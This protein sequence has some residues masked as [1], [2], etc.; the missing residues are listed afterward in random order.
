MQENKSSILRN[1][2]LK[3]EKE[4][5]NNFT[6]GGTCITLTEENIEPIKKIQFRISGKQDDDSQR[7]P[8]S[9][10]KDLENEAVPVV[11]LPQKF[12]HLLPTTS[13]SISSLA[14]FEVSK[15]LGKGA[16]ATVH[17]IRDLNTN[18]SF[19]LKTYAKT[20]FTKP[21]RIENIQ[22]E[23]QILSSLTHPNIVKLHY[24]CET[25]TKVHLIM[26]VGGTFALD[27]FLSVQEGKRISERK[28]ARIIRQVADALSYMHS[29]GV[30]HRDIKLGNVLINDKGKICVIDFGFTVDGGNNKLKNYCGTPCYMSPEI[31]E[32]KPYLGDKADVW[33]LGVMLFRLC[34]G[35]Q[36]FKGKSNELKKNIIDGKWEF[37][38]D[39]SHQLKK[40]FCMTFQMDPSLRC[41]M[42]D[43]L[44]KMLIIR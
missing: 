17:L 32:K 16:Y 7:V 24:T 4:N 14:S 3:K 31:V 1:S 43:V 11:L 41:N 21:H 26:A 27:T 8:R 12:H 28:A 20:Y 35:E 36:P 40:L 30:S 22:K 29:I 39:G 9:R 15:R 37:P 25:S 23:V 10:S 2:T 18:E 5:S 6:S 13:I 34:F 42:R 19:A 33:A 38:P 44:Q